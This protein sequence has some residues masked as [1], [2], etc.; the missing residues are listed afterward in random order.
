VTAADALLIVIL[1]GATAYAVLGGADFGGG[2][3]DLL[4]F[5]PRRDQQRAVIAGSMGPVWEA[6]HVWLIFVLIGLFGG[7]PT[8]YGALSRAL[9][10][11]LSLALL[12]MVLRGG[13]FVYHQ[14]GARTEWRWVFAISST[15]TPIMLGVTAGALAAGTL[16]G[17]GSDDAFAPFRSPLALLAGGLSLATAAFLAA[18]FLC[19]DAARAHGTQAP[20]VEDFRR[21][22]LA[23]AIVAGGL[24]LTGIV[25]LP[26]HAP[27]LADGLA[28]RGTPLAALSILG[29][30]AA[31]VLLWRRRFRAA[32][33]AAA[34]APAGVL[35]AWAAAQY[36]RFGVGALEVG[37]AAAPGPTLR[38]VLVILAI[39]FA[40]VVPALIILFRT[41]QAPAIGAKK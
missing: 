11:P 36:P 3:W 18:V 31:L 23:A 26:A 25:L 5:G 32:R 20:I 28:T 24:A 35:W 2:I 27:R 41:F 10:L 17:D 21:R 29:G 16:A 30:T 13:A 1:L 33:V 12:G 34:L 8:A 9:L 14:Y 38:V 7:F 39:G 37:P 4:A 6:N 15:L 22:A 40:V 19:R